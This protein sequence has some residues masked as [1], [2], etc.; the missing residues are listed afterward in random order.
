MKIYHPDLLP[1]LPAKLL[2][3]LHRDVC[4]L[5]GRAWGSSRQSIRY[6]WNQGYTTLHTYHMRVISE[7]VSRGWKP[8]ADWKNPLWRGKN[9]PKIDPAWMTY[10]VDK[11]PEHNAVLLRTQAHDLLAS[12]RSRPNLWSDGEF[13]RAVSLLVSRG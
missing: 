1:A 8:C 2:C 6:L 13:Q 7:M 5:R 3:A 9:M 12:H 11:Y 4:A 10:G